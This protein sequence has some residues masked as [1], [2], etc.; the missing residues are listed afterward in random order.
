MSRENLQDAITYINKVTDSKIEKYLF[1]YDH[2]GTEHKKLEDSKTTAIRQKTTTGLSYKVK[3]ERG[4]NLF[5]PRK[6]SSDYSLTSLDKTTK[7]LRFRF[8]TVTLKAFNN[9]IRF[10]QTS[11]ESLLIAAQREI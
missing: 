1:K 9:Y 7:E 2:V 8:K 6:K 4:G 11:H 10:L 5:D 3:C